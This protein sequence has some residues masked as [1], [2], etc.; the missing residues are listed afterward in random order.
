MDLRDCVERLT[1]DVVSTLSHAHSA[2]VGDAARHLATYRSLTD[3][4]FIDSLVQ[5]VQQSLH[6]EF[7][8]TTWPACP[9][10]PNHPLWFN[11]GWWWCE[12]DKVRVA[13]LGGLPTR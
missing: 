13:E 1:R 12:R 2:I 11:D 5:D 10:H 3:P 9:S 4:D 6:D 7:V 8:D